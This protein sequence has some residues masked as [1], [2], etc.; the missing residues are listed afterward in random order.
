L[1]VF[2]ILHFVLQILKTAIFCGHYSYLI[3]KGHHSSNYGVLK[4]GQFFFAMGSKYFHYSQ[5]RSRKLND[6]QIVWDI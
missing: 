1:F 6:L 4:N 3:C 2:D 5:N